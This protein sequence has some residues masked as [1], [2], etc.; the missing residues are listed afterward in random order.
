MTTSPAEPRVAD[1]VLLPAELELVIV[2]SP[3]ADAVGRRI[4]LERSSVLTLGRGA[5]GAGGIVDPRLSREHARIAFDPRELG[6]RIGDGQ[7]RNGTFVGGRSVKSAILRE[8]DVVR[9]GDTLSIVAARPTEP[10]Q[11]ER[12]QLAAT[13][14]L[15]VLLQGETGTGKEVLARR[16]H[17]QSERKGPFVALNCASIP[18]EIIAAELFGHTRG[19]FSGAARERE[20]LFRSADGGTLLL[21]EIG[22]MPVDLQAALLRVLQER[23]VRPVGSDH[24]LPVDVRVLSAT[25][26]D[27]QQGMESGRFRADLYARLAQVVLRVP[28]LRERRVELV[29]LLRE[30]GRAR[31]REL[32][33]AAEA[34]EVL[35]CW[36]FPLNVRELE[37]LVAQF[38]ASPGASWLLD[39]DFLFGVRP[40]LFQSDAADEDEKVDPPEM[41]STELTRALAQSGGKMAVA[42]R[43]LGISRQSLY[44]LMKKAGLSPDDYRQDWLK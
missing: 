35:L 30:L 33:L 40:E 20:G 15:S 42:A 3:D 12:V 21:D 19:A 14:G 11:A 23:V 34:A 31:G 6:F 27:L 41:G 7:S 25:H 24:E 18:R 26:A 9:I 17:E 37:S 38:C 39:A 43:D 16:L 2:F 32:T 8:H 29:P 22:D 10:S 13:S 44:R 5:E 1:R 4:G 36:D 28:P